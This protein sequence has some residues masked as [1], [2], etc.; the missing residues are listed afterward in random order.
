MK[1]TKIFSLVLLSILAFAM[2]SCQGEKVEYRPT[3]GDCKFVIKKID[4]KRQWGMAD[5]R[6]DGKY[7]YIP[8]QYDS[9]FSAYGAPY[10][11]GQLFIAVKDEKMYAWDFRGKSL[12]DGRAFASFVSNRQ[13]PRHNSSIYG[14]GIFH[15]AQTDDGII[16]FSCDHGRYIWEVFGP[17][18]AL[19][20]Q[21]SHILFKR[22]GKWGI[23]E[24]KWPGVSLPPM[25]PDVPCIYDAIISVNKYFWV[26][27][28]G[29]WS[30]IDSEGNPIRKSTALLNK[31]LKMRAMSA[32]EYKKKEGKVLAC[33]FTFQEVSFI[34]LDPWNAGYY[35]W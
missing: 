3:D 8:C 22:N 26:K 11:V 32:E 2:A 12:L 24:G 31:Y 17:A 4:G 23:Q 19:F 16:F 15:E 10:N 29:K 9:I 18:E 28:D 14:G 20:W 25:S 34:A 6:G 33:K 7:M 13:N 27:K 35:E 1:T 21:E 5:A 30:A